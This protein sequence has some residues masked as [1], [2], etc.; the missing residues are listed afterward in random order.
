MQLQL[1]LRQKGSTPSRFQASARMS[2]VNCVYYSCQSRGELIQANAGMC[3]LLLPEQ[4]WTN[5]GQC[6]NQSSSSSIVNQG[7]QFSSIYQLIWW[8]P[9]F[10]KTRLRLTVCEISTIEILSTVHH[11]SN[12]HQVSSSFGTGNLSIGSSSGI[13]LN[14]QLHQAKGDIS[15]KN[16]TFLW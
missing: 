10:A 7:R 4:G 12:Q 2:T 1:S 11:N 6:R 14:S 15:S 3:V 8:S 13:K 9:D 16:S 5:S